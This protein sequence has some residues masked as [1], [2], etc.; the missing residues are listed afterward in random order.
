MVLIDL[1]AGEE[2]DNVLGNNLLVPGMP[3]ETFIR[4]DKRSAISYLLKPLMDSFA[5]SMR[6]E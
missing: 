4:T 5:R 1:P 6:E 2:L 3:V